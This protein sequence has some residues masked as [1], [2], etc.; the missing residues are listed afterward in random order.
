MLRQFELVKSP[1]KRQLLELAEAARNDVLIN[2]PYITGDALS[3]FVDSLNEP[4]SINV[5]ISTTLS[6]SLTFYGCQR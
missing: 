3:M 5:S 1:W 2:A 4:D 6:S